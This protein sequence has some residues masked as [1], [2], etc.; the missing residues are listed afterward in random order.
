MIAEIF[1]VLTVLFL[2]AENLYEPQESDIKTPI[3][4]RVKMLS[5]SINIGN[6]K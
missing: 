2:L 6:E 5:I 3:K 4:V 1:I